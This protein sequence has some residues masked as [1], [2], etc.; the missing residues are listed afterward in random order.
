MIVLGREELVDTPESWPVVGSEVLA[1]GVIV[2]LVEDRIETPDGEL[3][4]REY[5]AH[6][7]AVGIIA[8]DDHDRVVLVRQY[9]HP[10]RHR[11]IEPPAGL[12]DVDG[13]DPLLAA[14]RELAEEVGLAAGTW[15]LLVDLFTTPG[16]IGEPLRIFLARDLSDVDAPDGFVRG[17]EEAHM[18]TVRASLEDLVDAVLDGRLH[19]PALVSGVLATWT[20]RQRDGVAGLRPADAPWAARLVKRLAG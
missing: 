1:H 9:R 4:K 5:L 8:L 15:H 18:D 3:I 7:G 20:A 13:E 19:N 12:L 14:R 2:D 17:G 6:P 16:I 10:V 11:L